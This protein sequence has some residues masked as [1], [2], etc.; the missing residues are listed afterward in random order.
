LAQGD[1]LRK[2]FLPS[3]IDAIRR[4]LEPIEKAAAMVT[5]TNQTTLLLAPVRAHSQKPAEFYGLVESLCPAS[6]YAELFARPR[7]HGPN[8]DLHGDEVLD[9]VA[10]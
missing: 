4:A 9:V 1:W 6:R 2:D 3:E 5:L 7:P 10:A 8:W